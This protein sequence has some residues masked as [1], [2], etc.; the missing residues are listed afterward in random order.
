MYP[1]LYYA[2]KDI[3]GVELEGLKLVNTFGFFVAISF[4]AAAWILTLELKRKQQ[5]GLFTYTE[6]KIMI[7]QPAGIGELMVN[8]LLGFIFGY[9][10]I[11]AFTIPDALA[12]PQSFILSS[13][14]NLLTGMIVALIFG[15]I[16]WW[17]KK[18]QQLDKP[19][20]RIVR[21]WPQ[22]RVGDIVIYAALFG[23]LGAKIFHNL[24]NWNEFT[25]DPIGSLISF[26]GL[27]FY[28]GLIC[29]G[30]A[31]IWYAKKHKIV[32]IHLV[33]A[34]APTMMLG[35]ALGRVGCQVSGDGDW[36]IVNTNPKPFNW[37]PDFLWAYKYPHNVINE[38]VPIPGCTGPYCNEL[39]LP[40]YPTALYEVV[41]CLILFGII[42]MLRKK[43]KVPGQLFGIY[44]IMNGAERFLIEKIRVN[45]KYDILFN[46]T[47]AE[48]ISLV[49]MVCGFFMVYF[50]TRAFKQK[51][52]Q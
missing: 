36:G 42:W 50:T 4:I 47:Q 5:Q 29:A 12:D 40:V 13:R 46:P 21:I 26:S 10:L 9:K 15:G 23:F 31:I 8:G 16:K 17:E 28:G 1:N 35:Y 34:M 3:F 48:L 22:D 38:G 20:E 41:M 32:P 24:E 19:E 49:L 6:E 7:G 43:I 18:K 52:A 25:K 27:T 30:A 11:G 2:F 37:M 45:T 33:D 39:P 14:G 51:T 44:L